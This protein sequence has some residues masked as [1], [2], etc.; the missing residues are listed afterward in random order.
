MLLDL[1]DK[2]ELTAGKQEVLQWENYPFSRAE[3]VT[4]PES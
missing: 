4:H 1:Y 2:R 3:L